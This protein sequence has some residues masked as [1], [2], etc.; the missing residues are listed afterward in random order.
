MLVCDI[1]IFN[2]VKVLLGDSFLNQKVKYKV[3][4]LYKTPMSRQK[5]YAVSLLYEEDQ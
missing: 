5:V 2:L 3:P 4:T 1:Y